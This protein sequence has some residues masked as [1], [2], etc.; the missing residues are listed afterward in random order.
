MTTVLKLATCTT[1]YTEFGTVNS[2]LAVRLTKCCGF[3]FDDPEAYQQVKDDYDPVRRALTTGGLHDMTGKGNTCPAAHLGRRARQYV[4][5]V[6]R[7]HRSCRASPRHERR[8][9]RRR[10]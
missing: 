6:L 1:R 4:S 3:I 9:V 10:P 7:P 2:F 5:C 8:H